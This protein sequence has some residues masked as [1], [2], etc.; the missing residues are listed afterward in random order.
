MA[1]GRGVL[2]IS[3][4][5]PTAGDPGHAPPVERRM[6]L[7]G[8]GG[9]GDSET[10]RDR[11]RQTERERAR[12]E[13]RSRSRSGTGYIFEGFLVTAADSFSPRI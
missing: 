2:S 12:E 7:D 10:D 4:K 6:A 5:G 9:S 8:T 11:Q 13:L 3:F 1:H